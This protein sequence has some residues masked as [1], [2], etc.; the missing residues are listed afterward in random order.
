MHCPELGHG[1]VKEV[2]ERRTLVFQ[3]TTE[4]SEENRVLD[5]Q[6][7][8]EVE[9][10]TAKSEDPSLIQNPCSRRKENDSDK[11]FTHTHARTHTQMYTQRCTHVRACTHM[12][13]FWRMDYWGLFLSIKCEMKLY[14]MAHICN[15]IT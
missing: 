6:D 12:L 13:L 5:H 11:L 9:V 8:S 15:A 7:G 2:E 4:S 14:I 3:V 1:L 10:L